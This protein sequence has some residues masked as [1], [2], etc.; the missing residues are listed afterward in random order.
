[1]AT[2]EDRLFDAFAEAE[3]GGI[4]DPFIRTKVDDAVGGSTAYGPVQITTGLMKGYKD[5]HSDLFTEDEL[6]YID[7]FL[8]QGALFNKFGNEPDKEGYDKKFDYGGSGTLTSE[9]DKELYN[10]V[11]RKML[12]QHHEDSKQDLD[13]T[14]KN[15]RFG[16]SSSKGRTDDSKYWTKVENNFKA[17]AP[18]EEAATTEEVKPTPEGAGAPV[19]AAPAPTVPYTTMTPVEKRTEALKSTVNVGEMAKSKLVTALQGK[20]DSGET[21]LKKMLSTNK[22]E[23][24]DKKA[25]RSLGEGMLN[26][27]DRIAASAKAMKSI[28]RGEE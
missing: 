28:G 19:K 15:W 18:A 5:N 23:A 2:A 6:T 14:I 20:I 17:S 25:K 1:M 21:S 13:K 11:A 24:K 8:E 27:R 16:S 22:K 26:L 9:S 4:A 12:K 10:S 3:T 7:S